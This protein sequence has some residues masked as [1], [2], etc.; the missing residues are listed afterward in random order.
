VVDDVDQAASI[1]GIAI[2]VR[3]TLTLGFM[4]N[5]RVRQAEPINAAS[6]ARIYNY[7]VLNTVGTFEEEAVSTDVMVRRMA[8]ARAVPLP[9]LVAELDNAVVGYAYA[10]RWKVR[11]GVSSL[12]GNDCLS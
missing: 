10:V 11:G 3:P 4:T 2:A 12:G 6:I 8:E 7:Y 1:N 9:W 5:L